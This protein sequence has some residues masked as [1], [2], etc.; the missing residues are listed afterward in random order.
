MPQLALIV[1]PSSSAPKEGFASHVQ[2]MAATT[3]GTRQVCL[4]SRPPRISVIPFSARPA[5]MLLADAVPA[6]AEGVEVHAYRVET[7]EPLEG[8]AE[9]PAMITLFSRRSGLSTAK[10]MSLWHEG[11]SPLALSVHPLVRYTRHRVLEALADAPPRDGIVLEMTARPEDL[12]STVRFF[13]GPLAA[14]PNMVRIGLDARRFLD[15]S[16]LENQLVEVR[17]PST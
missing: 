4:P 14:V 9:G 13:G 3:P 12:T 16:T 5:A 8:P 10:F 17:A 15:L 11:H 6:P 2:A 1:R 7:S